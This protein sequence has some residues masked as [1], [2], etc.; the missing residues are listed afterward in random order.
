MPI[1]GKRQEKLDRWMSGFAGLPERD[2]L[3]SGF[4][5]RRFANPPERDCLVSGFAGLPDLNRWL[6]G[7]LRYQS[8]IAV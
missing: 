5:A 1:L 8:G 7:L 6:S 4:L 2:R 3:V